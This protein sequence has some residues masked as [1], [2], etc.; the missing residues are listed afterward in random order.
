MLGVVAEPYAQP[1]HRACSVS[2]QSMW[3]ECN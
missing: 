2:F 1:D 3:I